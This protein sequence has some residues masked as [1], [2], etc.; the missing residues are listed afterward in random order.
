[1]RR[2]ENEGFKSNYLQFAKLRPERFKM[3]F[4]L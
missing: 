2:N 4:T 1:M 3:D